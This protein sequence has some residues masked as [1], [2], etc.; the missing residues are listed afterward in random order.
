METLLVRSLKMS[1]FVLVED[2]TLPGF[3]G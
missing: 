3:E 2:W 1:G